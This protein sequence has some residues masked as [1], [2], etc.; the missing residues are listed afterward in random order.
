MEY[1]GYEDFPAATIVGYL[2]TIWTTPL[3]VLALFLCYK[4]YRV[5]TNGHERAQR[6][7]ITMG[8]AIPVFA[9]I[10]NGV[11]F[12]LVNI[13]TP[14]FGHVAVLFFAFFSGYAILKYGL[15]TFDAAFAAENIVS[16]M[17]DSLILADINGKILSVN[18]QLVD[19]L[20][21]KKRGVER[22]IYGKTIF[23]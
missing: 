14:N 16:I 22:A 12:P 20:G 4:Y 21:Y 23:R 6:K 19:F 1:W 5:T 11:I 7:F 18:N 8:L 10:V 3:P 9:Y 2:S 13:R 17:P 15:F